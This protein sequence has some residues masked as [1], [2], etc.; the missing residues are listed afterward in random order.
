M[1]YNAAAKQIHTDL[2]VYDYHLPGQPNLRSLLVNPLAVFSAEYFSRNSCK[3]MHLNHH[4]MFIN[5][6]NNRCTK[7]FLQHVGKGIVAKKS[8]CMLVVY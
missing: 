1:D 6:T 4:K 3:E 2:Q 8:V 7:L 5:K